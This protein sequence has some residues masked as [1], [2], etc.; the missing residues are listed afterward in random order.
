MAEKM[1]YTMGEVS[2]MLDVTPSLLRFW[3]KH[4]DII[5]PHRNKKGNR[6]FTPDDVRNLKTIYHLVKERGMTLDG[7]AAQLR[8]R[9]G[10]ISRDM[11]IAERLASIRALLVEVRNEL[12][13]GG[14]LIDNPEPE[15]VDP[16][17]AEALESTTS[18]ARGAGTP[19]SQGGE[20][21]QA[22]KGDG[23]E[24]LAAGEI[25][26]LPEGGVPPLAGGG[27]VAHSLAEGEST[28]TAADGVV[29]LPQPESPQKPE[30]APLFQDQTLF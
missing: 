16:T 28:P 5:K 23:A 14:I 13:G 29:D 3:E 27:V 17:P 2:E 18:P 9:R 30:P 20:S 4:F 22:A 11:E 21:P 6:L 15:D 7:A 8:A 24:T 19:P 10:E 26:L 1:Y 25:P 12:S